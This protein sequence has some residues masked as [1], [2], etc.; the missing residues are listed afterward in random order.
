MCLR[1]MIFGALLVIGGAYLHDSIVSPSP[2]AGVEQR[3]LVNWE[4]VGKNLKHLA[5]RVQQE[6]DRLTG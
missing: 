6:W 5:A 1:G 4:V 2:A 3:Q